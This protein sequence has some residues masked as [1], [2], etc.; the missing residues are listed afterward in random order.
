[1][2]EADTAR[3][4]RWVVP[5]ADAIYLSGGLL[6]S[7]SWNIRD[8]YVRFENCDHFTWS[9]RFRV[10]HRVAFAC[11]CRKVGGAFL[12][13]ILTCIAEVRTNQRVT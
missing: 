5:Q 6:D 7:L 8:W 2:A 9:L 4:I 11:I 12:V 1:M 13:L 10:L 3:N